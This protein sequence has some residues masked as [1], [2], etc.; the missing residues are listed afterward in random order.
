MKKLVCWD[1][2]RDLLPSFVG[3]IINHHKDPYKPI[4]RKM[5]NHKGFERCLGDLGYTGG[6]IIRISPATN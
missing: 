6:S 4:I 5:E 1:Y 3:I 2:I